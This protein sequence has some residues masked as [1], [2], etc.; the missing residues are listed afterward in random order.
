MSKFMIVLN[1]A[2][3]VLSVMVLIFFMCVAVIIFFGKGKK[4]MKPK[5]V[6]LQNVAKEE[7]DKL[8]EYLG[9]KYFHPLDY[10]YDHKSL[11][12]KVYNK[13]ILEDKTIRELILEC[14]V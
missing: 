8:L 7:V 4:E 2:A 9:V 1:C 10:D 6:N 5:I 14:L 12:L 11:M 3:L 13:N